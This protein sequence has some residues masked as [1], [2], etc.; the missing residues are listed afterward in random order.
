[1]FWVLFLCLSTSVS[2]K[3]TNQEENVAGI[4]LDLDYYG[5]LEVNVSS[6]NLGVNHT[7]DADL[8]EG[9][10][11][12][13]SGDNANSGNKN[14]NAILGTNRKWPGGIIPYTYSSW[15]SQGQKAIIAKA[16]NRIH[17][18]TGLRFIFRTS[19]ADYIYI[20]PRS[21]CW[22]YVGRQGGKQ[23]LSLANGCFT[24]GI[25]LHELMH[26]AGFWH[27]QSRADRDQYVKINWQNI[28]E[29]SKSNFNK[30]SLST[31]SHLGATYDTCSVMHYGAYFF[32]KNG[33]PTIEKK[34][35][36]GCKI[37]EQKDFSDTDIRKLNT[38]YECTGYLRVGCTDKYATHC[39]R[40]AKT[41]CK[42]YATWMNRNCC[43]SC[44][45]ACKDR[46][47]N[48]IYWSSQGYCQGRYKAWM[49]ANC[50]KSCG[51]C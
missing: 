30:Y 5:K 32:S 4:A 1:M 6:L 40:W 20:L 18:T 3:K 38:M 31:I 51:T 23:E 46:Y 42:S 27:E 24:V 39:P 45:N 29:N 15:Y 34:N 19:Q 33:L 16:M 28:N 2:P 50:K 44:T 25:V 48:C 35:S 12:G 22:S 21:G 14:R 36:G 10:I 13:V 9:D 7:T 26:A 37:G 49:S 8:F 11:A 47:K 17:E 43:Q 41:Y